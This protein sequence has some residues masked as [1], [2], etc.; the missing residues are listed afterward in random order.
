M[1]YAL[2][3]IM[4]KQI[5][6]DFVFNRNVKDTYFAMYLLYIIDPFFHKEQN[7]TESFMD[8]IWHNRIQMLKQILGHCGP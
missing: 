1:V 4:E 7:R 2:N 5:Y 3:I 6:E 8:N